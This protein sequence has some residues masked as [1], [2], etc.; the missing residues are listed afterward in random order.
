MKPVLACAFLLTA[1]TLPGCVAAIGNT[2]YAGSWPR[3][4]ALLEQRTASAQRIVDLRQ[5]RL[6]ELRTLQAA[7]RGDASITITAEIELEES[8]MVLLDCKAQ[9]EAA[10]KDG[11]DD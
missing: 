11:D 8:R 4:R 7:G 5:Q 6:D 9:L 3:S 2:G 10:K 1:L